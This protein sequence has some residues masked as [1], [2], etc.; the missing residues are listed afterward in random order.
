MQKHSGRKHVLLVLCALVLLLL[1]ACGSGSSKVL[2][3]V[4]LGQKYLTQSEYTEA[5][6]AFTEAIQI[7]PDSMIAYLGRAQAYVALEQYEDAKTDYTTVLDGSSQSI[8][9]VEAYIGRAEINQIQGNLEN[10]IEDFSVAMELLNGADIPDGAEKNSL[11]ERVQA[12]LAALDDEN[13]LATE[14]EQSGPKTVSPLPLATVPNS[15][16][17]GTYDAD[18]ECGTAVSGNNL[19]FQ[20]NSCYYYDAAQ[21][22]SLQPG[23]TLTGRYDYCGD[24]AEFTLQIEEVNQLEGVESRW[25]SGMETTEYDSQPFEDDLELLKEGDR[26]FIWLDDFTGRSMLEQKDFRPI[27]SATGKM[28]DNIVLKV[29]PYGKAQT[30]VKGIDNVK[31]VLAANAGSWWVAGRLT[32]TVK[33]GQI[34]EITYAEYVTEEDEFA[35]S[36]VVLPDLSSTGAAAEAAKVDLMDY[37]GTDLHSFLASRPELKS[38]GATDG[39]EYTDGRMIVGAGYYGT[40]I[41]FASLSQ[42]CGYTI[43]GIECGMS[44]SDAVKLAEQ[45]Y[46]KA[47]ASGAGHYS[48][49]VDA[50]N[51]TEL[52]FRIQNG[53]VTEVSFSSELNLYE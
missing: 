39:E 52:S 32:V 41:D 20:V 37:L 28:A 18:L 26:Y 51:S 46:G 6:A 31:K 14:T 42:K 1:T 19:S 24:D 4:Q 29:T 23:D 16:S 45:R 13:G 17:D 10:A 21:I 22:E 53:K 48:Y 12:G 38:L 47:S 2:K 50:E 15:L 30:T 25:L 34:T 3:K 27:G 11:L 8:Q 9:K 36:D 33:N 43:V 40:K 49:T 5:V 35:Q 44:E 7:D